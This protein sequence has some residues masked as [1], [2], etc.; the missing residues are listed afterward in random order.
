MYQNEKVLSSLRCA[1]VNA[2][3]IR[4][5]L[6][7]LEVGFH[8][9]SGQA[10]LHLIGWSIIKY[11]QDYGL[12]FPLFLIPFCISR[13]AMAAWGPK[14]SYCMLFVFR[15]R[16]PT[17]FI[18]LP[19]KVQLSSSDCHDMRWSQ[20]LLASCPKSTIPKGCWDPSFCTTSY[21][22]VF[23]HAG[24]AARKLCPATTSRQKIVAVPSC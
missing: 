13:A 6:S 20:M 16:S 24:E 7:Y 22:P 3:M 8:H 19:S 1:G 17:T 4:H 21:L 11:H 2:K 18:H 12:M 5:F 9:C 14:T 15:W 23:S 10:I